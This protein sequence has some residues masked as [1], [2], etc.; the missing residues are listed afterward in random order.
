M[1]QKRLELRKRL[2]SRLKKTQK[3]QESQ[4]KLEFRLTKKPKR[5][6]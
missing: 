4:K 2:A 3:Q 6:A 5:N 1:R